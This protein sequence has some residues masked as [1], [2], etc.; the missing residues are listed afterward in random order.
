MVSTIQ[1]TNG[2]VA[3]L[4]LV[5]AMLVGLLSASITP[6]AAK[7][8]SRSIDVQLL[9]IND[10]HGNLE[11]PAGSSARVLT[12][13]GNV[14]NN[15]GVEYLA[16]KIKQLRA[17]NPN[18]LTVSAGDN[19]GASPLLSG[20]FHDEPTIEALNALGLDISAVGNHEFDE[21]SAEL[22][23]MQNGGC[24]PTDG[25]QDGDGFGGANFQYLS[26]N[27]F[28][29]G[30]NRTVFPAYTVRKF[31]GAKIAFIG[32]TLEGTPTIVT[33]SGVAGLEFRDEAETINALVPTLKKQNINAIV[34]LLHE[35]LAQ[36]PAS[37]AF[38]DTCNGPS[39]ALVDIVAHLNDA[40]DMVISG[41]THNQ[42]NCTLPNAVG[43]E[44]PVSSAASFGRLVTK[45]DFKL[46]QATK[47]I[48]QISVDN[49]IV[50]RDV[51]KD[52]VETAI[53]A[54][55]AAIVDGIRNAI[56]GSIQADLTRTIVTDESTLGNAIADGQLEAMTSFGAQFA[57]MNPGGIRADLLCGPGDTPGHCDVT[58]G[59]VFGVQP[60]QNDLVAFNLTGAQID[61]VLE[62][63]FNNPAA[64]QNRFLSVSSNFT[65]Q[66]D[67]TQ[68][69]GN[70]VPD[71]SI[72]LNGTTL[73]PGTTY[74]LVA[75]SF[76]STG[77]D[78][79]TVLGQGTNRVI[80]P[81]DSNAFADYITHHSPVPV[82]ALNRVMPVGP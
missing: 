77:G 10:F 7:Q 25:C 9:A 31:G 78:N 18:T 30:T 43:R 40:I 37:A 12:E 23:R 52:P 1:P 4:L 27:V 64:G 21:G 34:V 58:F 53:I 5:L 13:A 3:R 62:Q 15:G 73:D 22:L 17:L 61:D 81:V 68:A 6:T 28:Y 56:V 75:N 32:L 45:I 36:T 51:A 44:V 79:F 24:H 16:T 66:Y 19:I 49:Q 57:L 76:L 2:R 41:H 54:K 69:I 80:G 42:Y 65:Y 72:M 39:G 48:Y 50:T 38:T 71:A 47:D 63:Q 67:L 70:R 46:D 11:P 82:P 20:Y 74:R 59:E 26:A 60:F 14:E 33:P 8:S 55:Y 29:A 35:G